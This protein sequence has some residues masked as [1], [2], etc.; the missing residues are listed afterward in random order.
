MTGKF[1]QGAWKEDPVSE[2]MPF[3]KIYMCAE[4]NPTDPDHPVVMVRPVFRGHLGAP[5][6]A[7]SKVAGACVN[8]LCD[9]L[10]CLSEA[11][12]DKQRDELKAF[13]KEIRGG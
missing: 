4:V 11:D 2:I 12:K 3:M 13:L 6:S 10:N 9:A 8:S 1:V 7:F 5:G